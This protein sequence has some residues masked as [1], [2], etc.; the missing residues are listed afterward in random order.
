MAP[1]FF[2]ILQSG[3]PARRNQLVL[4]G[5]AQAP[6]PI[7]VG[8]LHHAFFVDIGAEETGTETG[9][10]SSNSRRTSRAVQAVCS[11]QP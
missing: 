5:S 7:E 3:D 4:R 8:S 2:D 6:K 11:C 10:V 1:Q 9:T